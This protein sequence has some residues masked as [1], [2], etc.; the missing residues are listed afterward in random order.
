MTHSFTKP[1][2][3]IISQEFGKRD[4]N[5]KNNSVVYLNVNTAGQ[6]VLNHPTRLKNNLP[7]AA[8]ELNLIIK[9]MGTLGSG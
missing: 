3:D 6:A 4:V 5:K 8:F 9:I 7:F 1:C 2:V